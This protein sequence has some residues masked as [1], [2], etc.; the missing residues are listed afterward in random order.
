MLFV[1]ARFLLSSLLE[2]SVSFTLRLFCSFILCSLCSMLL[3]VIGISLRNFLQTWFSFFK[4]SHFTLPF[5]MLLNFLAVLLFGLYY[6]SLPLCC[7]CFLPHLLYCCV[8]FQH[9]QVLFCLLLPTVSEVLGLHSF[10]TKGFPLVSLFLPFLL[11]FL[12]AYTWQVFIHH[13]LPES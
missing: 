6:H 8:D 4:P 1:L 5:S 2:V 3:F 11:T 13:F 7:R 9:Y 12:V 10:N